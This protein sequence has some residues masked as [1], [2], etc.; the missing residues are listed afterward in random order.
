VFVELFAFLTVAKI[1]AVNLL[2]STYW[3]MGAVR[4]GDYIAKVR[5]AP[6][7]AFAERVAH[8]S[9]LPNSAHEVYRPALVAELQARHTSSTSRSSSAQIS[10]GCPCRM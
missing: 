5:I 4:H 6:A 7:A 3:T 9:M 10:S 1:P 8:R 2:L